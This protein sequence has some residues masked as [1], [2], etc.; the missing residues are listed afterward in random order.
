MATATLFLTSESVTTLKKSEYLYL[1]YFGYDIQMIP[2]F[3]FNLSSVDF[4][5]H[6]W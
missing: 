2:F 1:V 4:L 3:S 5:N 6:Y